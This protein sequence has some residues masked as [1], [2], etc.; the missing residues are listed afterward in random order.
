MQVEKLP[1]GSEVGL[2]ARV[3]TS[4]GAIRFKVAV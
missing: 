4:M 1:E 3:E 2:H